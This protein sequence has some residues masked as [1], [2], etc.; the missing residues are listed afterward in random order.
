MN[1]VK[2]YL[3]GLGATLM[4]ATFVTLYLRSHL[5]AILVDLC[6]TVPRAMFWLAFSNVALLLIPLIFA[7]SYDP[8]NAPAS[9]VLAISAQLERSLLGLVFTV[10]FL[11]IVLGSFIRR[12]PPVQP[13]QGP[14]R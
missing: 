8:Q 12:N 14:M 2:E 6:G 4:A 7:M 11:G 3:T 9:P 13:T 5:K 10:G 1:A